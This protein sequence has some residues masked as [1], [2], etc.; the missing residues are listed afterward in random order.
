M[1]IY[2]A[3]IPVLELENTLFCL[4]KSDEKYVPIT[5]RAK[6]KQRKNDIVILSSDMIQCFNFDEQLIWIHLGLSK[7][8]TVKHCNHP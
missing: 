6:T 3:I 2:C 1:T 8:F 4:K 7:V 5:I